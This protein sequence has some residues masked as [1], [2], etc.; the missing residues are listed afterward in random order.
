MI[1]H[2]KGQFWGKVIPDDTAV[3]C[4][5]MAKLVETRDTVW[6]TDSGG[7]KEA[8]GRRGPDLPCEGSIFRRK[9]TSWHA[10]DTL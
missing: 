8:C 1:P 2:A 4:E 5:K 6:V 10:D 3:S 7:P 9:N